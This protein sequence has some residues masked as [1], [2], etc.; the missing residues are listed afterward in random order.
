MA[1]LY[2]VCLIAISLF[3]AIG[4]G[5]VSNQPAASSSGAEDVKLIQRDEIT[6]E[7]PAAANALTPKDA[8]VLEREGDGHFYA[9][10][11]VNNMPIRMV[12]D[13]GA[14]IIAL[15]RD[16]ARK[17]GLAVS[18]GMF[19]VV[20][21]GA[22]GDV[23]GESAKL[24]SVTLGHETSTEV[25]AIILDTGQ[26]SLLGQSFLQQFESVEIKGDTMVLR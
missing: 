21:S 26:Q 2:L 12:V 22:S 19:E 3:G 7:K 16:D 4:T 18:A 10:V 5:I 13:T 14:S 11:K 9:E 23:H 15:S 8:V 6:Q 17:A 25:P 1:R 20:G 24:D